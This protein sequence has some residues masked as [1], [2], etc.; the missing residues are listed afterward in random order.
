MLP[1]NGDSSGDA[2]G[3]EGTPS[4]SGRGAGNALRDLVDRISGARVRRRQGELI[5]ALND[6]AAAVSSST[7]VDDVLAR[8]VER[9]KGITNTEKAA[10][11]LTHDHS[12]AIDLDTVVV[13]GSRQEHP[14]EWW[15]PELE[16]VSAVVFRDGSTYLNLNE[17]N[18]AWLLCVPILVNERPIGMLAAINSRNHE[19][20]EDQVDFLEILSAFAA[21]AIENARLA[22]QTRYV[23]LSSERDR[24]A[25]E[26]HDGISQ[27][28][29]S[30]ALG[31]E[32]CRKMVMREPA[33]VADRL[34][35]LQQMV[36]V[37][38]SELRRFIYDLRPIKLAELGLAGAIEYWVHQV[39]TGKDIGGNLLIEGEQRTLTPN[40]EACLY[41]V[42]KESVSN[43][44]KH[45]EAQAFE[46]TLTFA[47]EGVALRISDDGQ[48]FESATAKRRANEGTSYGLR[49]IE[50]RVNREH[51][52]LDVVSEPGKGTTIYVRLPV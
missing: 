4:I 5:A 45:S 6:V 16:A 25:R 31:L 37:S 15:G 24:I 46:I 19:F 30:V 38:R 32:V 17:E 44:V 21:T 20:S 49:S 29:F 28:L 34:E 13:R 35:E 12:S 22:E 14:E 33:V 11:V 9:A 41:Q 23:L 10:L 1:R 43:I 18:G 42:A 40:A 50:E 48:G 3:T 47:D 39:T 52:R 26:M 7:S 2:V 8:I 27:S 36:D 51:G